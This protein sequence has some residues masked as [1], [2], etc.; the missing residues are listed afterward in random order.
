[1]NKRWFRMTIVQTS[2]PFWQVHTRSRS[3]YAY[4]HIVKDSCFCWH[5]L[6]ESRGNTYVT[7]SERKFCVR[8]V[9]THLS[10]EYDDVR[11]NDRS[12]I[13][14]FSSTRCDC[15]SSYSRIRRK[16]QS[17]VFES[18]WF[19]RCSSMMMKGRISL[20]SDQRRP[21]S[22]PIRIVSPLHENTNY[23]KERPQTA[24]HSESSFEEVRVDGSDD[25]FNSSPVP[26]QNSKKKTA[27]PESTASASRTSSN[28]HPKQHNFDGQ[29][30]LDSMMDDSSS[31][32]TERKR[33]LKPEPR[34]TTKNSSSAD[35][36]GVFLLL[37]AD[38]RLTV[39]RIGNRRSLLLSLF[40]LGRLGQQRSGIHPSAAVLLSRSYRQV[41][42]H[43][44]QHWR[45]KVLHPQPDLL[46][47]TKQVRHLFNLRLLHHGC[48]VCSRRDLSR[49]R[50]R[51]RRSTR[52]LTKR[53]HPQS[54]LA[55]DLVCQRHHYLPNASTQTA[56]RH[57][58]VSVGCLQ[59]FP[60][61][62]SQRTGERDAYL[63]SGWTDVDD[64]TDTDRLSR[65]TAHRSTPRS[66]EKCE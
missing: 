60:Q 23:V 66:V 25:S 43:H 36:N 47:W 54:T 15:R 63:S 29:M 38:E 37:D 44:R 65:D 40:Y 45:R 11:I 33:P 56:E 64:G 49:S 51:H 12:N 39:R 48:L 8:D 41:R 2:R 46:R 6:I 34:P 5:A 3:S 21:E 55:K 27:V 28:H 61:V 35:S 10:L 17:D 13:R 14:F 32:T 7:L 50:P 30:L 9:R 57:V 62:L 16:K 22:K 58:P 1:M 53:Q 42:L 52:P 59:C 20:C 26:S 4:V 24:R 31:T 19:S 18:H